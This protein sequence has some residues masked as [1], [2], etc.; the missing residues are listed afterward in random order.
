MGECTG[1]GTGSDGRHLANPE[2]DIRPA[3]RV[4]THGTQVLLL[5]IQHTVPPNLLEHGKEGTVTPRDYL[6]ER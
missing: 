4:H 2:A 3:T 1:R 6:L 5:S